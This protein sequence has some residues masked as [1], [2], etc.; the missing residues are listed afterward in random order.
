[1]LLSLLFVSPAMS[2]EGIDPDA[3]KI[4]RSMSTYLGSLTMFSMNVDGGYEI[5]DFSGQK[6]QLNSSG[7]M[8]VERPGKLYAHRR[9]PFADMVIIFDG[10]TLTLN[11]KSRNVYV[12]LESPGTI[13]DAIRSIHAET[14]LETPAGDL[15]YADSYTGLVTDV[16]KGAYLGTAYVNGVE[17]HHLAFR[18]A[19][20]D[21][22]LWVKTGNTPLPM[23]YVITSK[24]VT[25]APQY[26]VQFRDW[27]TRPQINA[28]QF[29][30]SP[31]QGSKRL[32]TIEANEIGELMKE[33]K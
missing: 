12:S 29:V 3:D 6:L 4:L 33:E 15:L 7:R 21:W 17:C 2:A 27:N 31:P 19:K 14:G 1:M 9:G 24:W 8:I 10:K 23:K 25:G 13:E 32:E 20:V 28:N 22:Q 30:F 16:T 11:E 26:S 18:A 5:V